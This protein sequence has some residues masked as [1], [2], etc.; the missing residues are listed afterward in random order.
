M[1]GKLILFLTLL[2]AAGYADISRLQAG[3]VVA[4]VPLACAVLARK[5]VRMSSG[6]AI[7]LSILA[8]L[9]GL[10]LSLLAVIAVGGS[11]LLFLEG[12]M[13]TL[14]VAASPHLLS[15]GDDGPT[16]AALVMIWPALHG[17][18]SLMVVPC[19]AVSAIRTAADRPYCIAQH[20][21]TRA[22]RSWADLRGLS[23]YTTRTGYKSTSHWYL[24]AVMIVED[25]TEMPV[26]NW[27][28]GGLRFER[29]AEPDWL[30]EPAGSECWPEPGFLSRLWPV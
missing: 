19:I 1:P 20:R 11:P 29:L 15:R 24:H 7:G 17:L 4:F 2:I 3:V 6:M 5:G 23:L 25:A 26:F 27:S 13:L 22:L 16:A 30:L 9:S 12:T 21:D 28:F 10:V 14:A 8:A 18:W